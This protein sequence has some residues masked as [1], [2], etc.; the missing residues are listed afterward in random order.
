[1]RAASEI[2][3]NDAFR[4]RFRE[5]EARHPVNKALFEAWSVNL[6]ARSDQELELLIKRR[7]VVRENFMELMT[8]PQFAT[9]V[10]QGTGD[11]RKVQERFGSISRLLDEV[12]A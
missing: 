2:F 1:M 4:K 11:A 10:S 7:Q 9:A 3:E 5:G 12:L 8:S 6:D